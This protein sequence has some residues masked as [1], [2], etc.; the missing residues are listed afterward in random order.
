MRQRRHGEG[1][2]Q[3][4]EPRIRGGAR[5]GDHEEGEDQQRTALHLMQRNG[6]RIAEPKRAADQQCGMAD[7]KEQRDVGALRGLQHQDGEKGC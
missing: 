2:Q 1:E 7:E 6:Q 4:A 3:T 5:I